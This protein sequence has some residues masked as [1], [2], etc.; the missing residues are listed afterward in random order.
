MDTGLRFLVL[1]SLWLMLLPAVPP[2][3]AQD[4]AAAHAIGWREA[5]VFGAGIG[6]LMLV[7]ESVNDGV[8][9]SRS[10]GQDVF[11]EPF[12]NFGNGWAAG[13]VS[14]GTLVAG[15]ATG[16]EQLTG[17]GKRLAATVIVA[18]GAV[19]ITKFLVGRSRPD[20]GEGSS[21]YHP[22][23]GGTSFYSGH[24]TSAFAL[25]TALSM[26]IHSPY[27]TAVLF[28]TAG[29]AGYSRMYDNKHWL[30]DV[31]AGAVLGIASAKFVYGRWTIFGLRAPAIGVA[32]GGHGASLSYHFEF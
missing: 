28:T 10:Q 16:D 15:L 5:A 29:L 27:A 30:S 11:L 14:G 21:S 9:N 25:A 18:G 7:D 3:R 19:T 20:A 31:A 26:E 6:V 4:R 2:V 1:A 22:F 8:Q 17:V 32:P 13:L 12:R 23:T 24:T